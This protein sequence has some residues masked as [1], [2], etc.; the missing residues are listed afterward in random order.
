MQYH[1][2]QVTVNTSDK[3]PFFMGSMLRGAMGYTLKKVTCINPSYQCEGC[4]AQEDCLYYQFYEAKNRVHQYRFEIDLNAPTLRFG[5]YLFAEA[6]QSVAYVMSALQMSLS[7]LGLGRDN[8]TYSDYRI[9]LNGEE[10]YDGTEFKNLN[11]ESKQFQL[12]SFCPNVKIRLST[13]L[14]IKKNNRF[15]RDEIELEEMLRS[16][17]QREQELMT[18][19]KVYKLPY[20]PSYTTSVKA[21]KYQ[22]LVRKSNR[23]KQKLNMDG[24]IGEIAVMGLDQES[25]RLL[26]LGEIIGVGKQTVMGLGRIEVVDL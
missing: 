7:E 15:L 25:Y 18:K 16:I 3:P 12:D 13:P 14:R 10:V 24:M 2:I 4:F 8:R 22:S 17:Y 21:L 9:W 19:E 20:Q 23:Q 6:T 11:I 1:Y 5:L 26:R